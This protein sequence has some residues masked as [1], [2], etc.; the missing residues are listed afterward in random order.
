MLSDSP[1]QTGG[2]IIGVNTHTGSDS[3]TNAKV[4]AVMKDRN[5]K[6]SRMDLYVGDQTTFRDQV[7][8][9]RATGGRVEA[10]MMT[11]WHW[12][13]SCNPNL[14]AVEQDSYNQT[15]TIVNQVKDL[16]Q[17]F[18]MLNEVQLR[19]DIQS[20]VPWNSAGTSTT[21]YQGKPCVA[22]ITAVLRGMSRAIH[23]IGASS[24]LPLRAILGAVGKDFGFLSYMQQQGV[25]WDV[26]GYHIYP[27]ND[28]PSMLSD[29]WFGP[30]GPIAQLAK[31]NK[32]VHI[33]EFNCGE[34]Y[35]SGYE[36]QAGMPKTETCL[37]ALTRHMKDLRDQKI[38]NIESIHLYELRDET[39]KSGPESHF[40]LM[41]DLNTPKVHLYLVSAFAGGSLT[42]AERNE[43][44]SRG[45][46]TNPEIDAMQAAAR[47]GGV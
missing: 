12:D 42:S 36:N 31:F 1:T 8:K 22:T 23:D 46:L 40:G 9:V 16:V 19:S 27:T 15:A 38:A 35:D 37:K 30:G 43:L 7:Q 4:A 17:D 21:P 44:T 14:S 13:T 32:P 25:Q 20:E 33:N 11:S 6:S 39:N 3:T 29:P 26:T 24:G 34:I 45:L 47:A 5:L 18:E 41:Y 10:V 2:L 28:Y